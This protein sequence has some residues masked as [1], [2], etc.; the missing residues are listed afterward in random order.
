M[1]AG[2]PDETGDV[3]PGD[4]E[5]V[6]WVGLSFGLGMFSVF[7]GALGGTATSDVA[8]ETLILYSLPAMVQSLAVALFVL[9]FVVAVITAGPS[10]LVGFA[11]LVAGVRLGWEATLGLGLTA[12]GVLLI[13]GGSLFWR[14]RYVFDP[15]ARRLGG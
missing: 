2:S 11:V 7:F 1:T 3:G 12:I 13:V 9:A 5:S 8:V 14:G 15:V 6:R 4:D 10:G